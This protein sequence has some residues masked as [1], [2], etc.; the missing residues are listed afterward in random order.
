MDVNQYL[1]D[2]ALVDLQ[3][4]FLGMQVDQ[5]AELVALV[6]SAVLNTEQ[7]VEQ[8][9]ER[10]VERPED[11]D[12]APDDIAQFRTLDRWTDFGMSCCK[13]HCVR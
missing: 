2:C 10:V 11:K 9:A 6:K 12:E 1:D 3:G 5:L 13:N 4:G 8:E 7:V